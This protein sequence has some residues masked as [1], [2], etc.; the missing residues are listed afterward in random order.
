MAEKRVQIEHPKT[1]RRYE[2]SLAD[3][4]KAKAHRN[5]K[6]G[7]YETYAD[8]G[9]KITSMANGQPYDGPNAAPKVKE[10]EPVISGPAPAPEPADESTI[11]APD[12]AV[13]EKGS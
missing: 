4:T 3:F 1:G 13:A 6:T 11:A 12:P 2:V 9:F 8:A 5:P 7:E 10:T